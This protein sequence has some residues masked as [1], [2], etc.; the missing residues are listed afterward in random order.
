M[1]EKFQTYSFSIKTRDQ[2]SIVDSLAV[3]ASLFIIPKNSFDGYE[4][5]VRHRP[6]IPDN[7]INW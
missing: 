5:E 6:V 3:S 1:L 4:V 7:I 2:N